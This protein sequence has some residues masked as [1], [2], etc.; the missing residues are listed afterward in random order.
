MQ[1]PMIAL[2]TMPGREGHGPIARV[3]HIAP[4]VASAREISEDVGIAW[5]A[6]TD[7]AHFSPKDAQI[8]IDRWQRELD[9]GSF[10]SRFAEQWVRGAI[11]EMRLLTIKGC[12]LWLSYS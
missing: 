7:T 3:F 9:A 5:K 1:S 12:D 11:G 2:M 4:T 10:C 6:D 8:L